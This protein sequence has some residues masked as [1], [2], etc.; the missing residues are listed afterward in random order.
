ME[1]F[2]KN[3]TLVPPEGYRLS[4]VVATGSYMRV[5]YHQ[6]ADTETQHVRNIVEVYL[7]DMGRE[8]GRTTDIATWPIAP[9]AS[10]KRWWETLIQYYRRIKC[11]KP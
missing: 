4:G 11:R 9:P 8:V 7:N 1:F 6:T 10:P 2:D 3:Q 5:V